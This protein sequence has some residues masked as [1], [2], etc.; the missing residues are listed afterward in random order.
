MAQK[1]K[2]DYK[3]VTG[4]KAGKKGKK[5]KVS[6]GKGA[7]FSSERFAQPQK[8]GPSRRFWLGL[9]VAGVVCA[10]LLGALAFV[11]MQ[12]HVENVSVEGNVHYT[13]EEIEEM[14]IKD[15]L[16]ANSLYLSFKY[17]NKEIRNIPFIEKM[18]VRVDSPN[19]ITIR[20]Y[21][22][23]VAGYV[24]YMGRYMYFDRE[25]IVVES[26]ETRTSGVPQ[27]TGIDFDH[28]VLYEPLPVE[29]TAI[30]SEV[31]SITQMLS[32]YDIVTD[33]IFFNSENEIT[34]Y[35]ENVRARLG[36]DDL[37]EK[38][39]RLQQILPNLEGETGVL[40]MQ[41]YSDDRKNVTFRRDD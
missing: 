2:Q 15:R 20:V 36:K 22:K 11:Q 17:R 4:G 3:L 7:F 24:E 27:V 31:L 41:N 33:K 35:F 25:G 21:E 5:K 9:A 23:T 16:S 32:K 19:S 13:K 37:E 28:V 12:F 10:V 38:V 34:L 26:S 18:S 8:R 40:D 39:M 30:F 14:V 29:D 1:R 6:G